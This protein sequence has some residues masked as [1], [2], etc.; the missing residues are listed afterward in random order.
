[1]VE[2][3]YDGEFRYD[4][5]P[6]GALQALA[7]EHVV[8][9]GT[10]SK[11]LAPAV[12]LGWLVLPAG[13]V[14]EVVEAM[15]DAVPSPLQQLTLADL[16]TTGAFDRH[17]RRQRLAYRRRRDRLVADVRRA[18]PGVTVSGVAAGMHAVLELPQGW[19]EHALVEAAAA[20]GLALHGMTSYDSSPST[21]RPALVVGFG[22]PA[23]HAFATALARLCAVL[24]ERSEVSSGGA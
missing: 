4:R 18:A 23:D 5:R 1:V 6:V 22:T 3:D 17:V 21:R 20:R 2:D 24:A 7:P 11:S 14:H 9:A 16:I 10:A 15:Q 8:Y 12:R 19:D 13:L